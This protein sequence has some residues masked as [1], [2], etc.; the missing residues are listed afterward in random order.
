MALIAAALGD[1]LVE[2]I[3]NTGIFG[4]AYLDGNHMS[5][6]PTLIAGLVLVLQVVGWRCLELLRR[7]RADNRRLGRDWVVD[8][9]ARFA[10]RS[11]LYDLPLIFGLQIAALFAME[12]LEQVLFGG[13]AAGVSAWLGGPAAFSLA[14]H[15]IVGAACTLLFAA[16]ARALAATLASLVR[17][18]I[19]AILFS[20]GRGAER[21]SFRRRERGSTSRAQ[22]PHVR[23]LGGRA[24][25]RLPLSA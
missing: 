12:T 17:D 8:V 10:Q 23:Q 20:L 18:A 24:P 15:A 19:D 5:V 9:A 3:S 1:A 6:V 2:S 25:P 14:L 22:A 21:S 7:S 13:R 11:P 16:L 4:T